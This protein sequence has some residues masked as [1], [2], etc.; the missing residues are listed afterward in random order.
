MILV[1]GTGRCG[2]SILKEILA[3]HPNAAS[4]PF[5]YRFIIDPDGIIDFYASY[6][7]TWSPYIADRK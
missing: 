4:L 1:G 3:T 7:A 2:T 5:E 6:T